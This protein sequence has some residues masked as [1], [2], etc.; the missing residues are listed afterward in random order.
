MNILMLAPEFFPI[1]GGVGT[2]IIELIKNMPEDVRIYVL[3]PER[4]G[5]NIFFSSNIPPIKHES[6]LNRININYIGK[7]ND[8]FFNN[9]IF[10]VNCLKT[11]PSMIKRYD[12]DL[13]HSQSAMPDLFLSPRLIGVPIITT[14]HT[15]IRDEISSIKSSGAYF[16]D[17]SKSEKTMVLLSPF[18][19]PLEKIYYG[20]NRH[21]I[22]VSNWMKTHVQEDFKNINPKDIKV[23]YNGVNSI[24]FNPINKKFSDMHF[25]EL[26]DIDTPKVLFLSRWV[27]RKGIKYLLDAIPKI[28]E[29]FDVHFIFAGSNLNRKL[30]ISSK[31]CSFL[32][33][34][35]QEKLPYLYTSCD[36]FI[37]P[38]LYENF[39]IC[40]LE[41]MSSGLAVISTNVGGIPEMITH[42]ENGIIIKPKITKDIIESIEHLI[43]NNELRR[44]LGENA[45]KTVINKFSWTRIALETKECYMRVLENENI[46]C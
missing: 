36:I 11:I 40:L 24:I 37:L 31:N 18:L 22:T 23:I 8:N 44:K 3:T 33:Y 14:I 41:A 12:I 39:P 5:S 45:R 42:G 30:K 46:N 4:P 21:Y 26:S 6:S 2:Y 43:E 29:K 17:L 25:P 10:Q 35:P 27:E 28:C 20:S 16:S 32:G 19:K 15:T 34:I 13:I 9:F 38:S 7:A 1:T